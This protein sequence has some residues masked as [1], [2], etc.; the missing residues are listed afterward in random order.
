MLNRRHGRA[1]RLTV[2]AA[3]TVMPCLIRV[4]YSIA[5]LGPVYNSHIMVA[6]PRHVL[7]VFIIP[8]AAAVLHR[9]CCV[10]FSAARR[11]RWDRARGATA[12]G[13]E[14]SCLDWRY[15]A[16]LRGGERCEEWTSAAME[17]E[18]GSAGPAMAWM[19]RAAAKIELAS[20]DTLA[21]KPVVLSGRRGR[22]ASRYHYGVVIRRPPSMELGDGFHQTVTTRDRSRTTNTL[23]LAPQ[24]GINKPPPATPAPP[25]AGRGASQIFCDT[26]GSGSTHMSHRAA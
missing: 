7:A 9:A 10:L 20:R 1:R 11:Q 22:V 17:D 2:R 21:Q 3:A 5:V 16:R 4:I 15:W 26:R 6:H 13:W 24:E 25:P 8:C 14:T 23:R 12:W 19:G 18:C